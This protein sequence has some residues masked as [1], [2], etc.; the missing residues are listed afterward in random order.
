M[1]KKTHNNSIPT[2]RSKK[3][4]KHLLNEST[5]LN[6]NNQ[7]N[8]KTIIKQRKIWPVINKLII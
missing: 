7:Y 5:L 1:S 3:V 2:T 6:Y 4:N 8:I